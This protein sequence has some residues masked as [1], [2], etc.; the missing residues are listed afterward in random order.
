MTIIPKYL[1]P[2]TNI[3]NVT[4]QI[5]SHYKRLVQ[6]IVCVPVTAGGKQNYTI[7]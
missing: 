2:I 6:H 5:L 3:L 7:V 4:N 1:C